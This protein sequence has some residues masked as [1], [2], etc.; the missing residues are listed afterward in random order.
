MITIE[1]KMTYRGDGIYIGR[2]SLLGNP[3]RIGEDGTRDEVIQLYRAWLWSQIN[4]RGKVY[5]ELERLASIARQGDLTLIC[6]CK[7]RDRDVSC[8]GD[9]VKRA[10][11]WLNSEELKL[12][13]LC[14]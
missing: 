11:E 14:I 7:D 3:F 8:H 2:P 9:L 4:L 12:D 1:N 13:Y 10:I 5:R 6:W